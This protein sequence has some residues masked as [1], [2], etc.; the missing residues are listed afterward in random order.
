MCSW[1]FAL[2]ILPSNL[3]LQNPSV[4]R[5]LSR[6]FPVPLLQPNS[7]REKTGAQRE[8][9]AG[10]SVERSQRTQTRLPRVLDAPVRGQTLVRNR[11]T[12]ALLNWIWRTQSQARHFRWGRFIRHRAV[13]L[14]RG[15]RHGG[16]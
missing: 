3:A 6:T 16:L 9:L 13:H 1:L 2:T 10:C 4:A 15:D 11:S 8:R 7:T 14:F 12:E 5:T